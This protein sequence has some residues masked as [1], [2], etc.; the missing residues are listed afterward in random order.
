MTAVRIRPLPR[1]ER[2]R[3]AAFGDTAVAGEGP[4]WV[5]EAA[6][7]PIG[8]A[9][10]DPV[11]GLP[12]LYSLHGQV[13]PP[14]RRQGVG[15]RLL[16]AAVAAAPPDAERLSAAVDDPD[17][18][19]GRFL[20]A[21]GFAPEHEEWEMALTPLPRRA[22]PDLP[23]GLRWAGHD[24]AAALTHF[25]NLYDAIFA[26]LPWYQ[27]FERSEADAL[28]ESAADLLF[29][30]D[31]PR[32]VG[33]AWLHDSGQIEPLGLL[34]AYRKRGLG[35][36]LLDGALA[37]LAARGVATAVVGVWTTNETA[38]RLYQQAGFHH[39]KSRFYLERPLR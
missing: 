32:P 5:A 13:A 12:G 18:P 19:D 24:R 14:Y 31:G 2:G 11:P 25:L 16:A 3:L 30:A 10:I 15:A 33:V 23:D 17:G 22:R 38:V 35:R 34:P 21:Q 29:L 8:F 36:L 4:L 27:P 20:Q 39:V 9:A 28:L 6:G 26:G 37:E 1:S 7:K